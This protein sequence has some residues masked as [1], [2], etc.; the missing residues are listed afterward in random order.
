VGVVELRVLLLQWHQL[1][2][3]THDRRLL[4]KR[5]YDPLVRGHDSACC[6]CG[7][8]AWRSLPA[9]SFGAPRLHLGDELFVVVLGVQLIVLRIAK[10]GHADLTI[11]RVVSPKAVLE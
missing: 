3:G 8:H 10:G 7:G 11:W 2:Y 9:G 5:C 4:Q 1:A 6:A